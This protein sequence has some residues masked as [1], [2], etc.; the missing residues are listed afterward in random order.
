MVI[1]HL[2]NGMILQV[3]EPIDPPTDQDFGIS[4]PVEPLAIAEQVAPELSPKFR[5]GLLCTR[6]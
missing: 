5:V 2:L 1:N 4:E 3:D 6:A